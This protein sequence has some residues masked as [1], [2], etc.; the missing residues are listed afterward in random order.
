MHC[1]ETVIVLHIHVAPKSFKLPFKAAHR[2]FVA[3]GSTMAVGD[4]CVDIICAER[5]LL[6]ESHAAAF[7]QNSFGVLPPLAIH[8]SYKDAP[9]PGYTA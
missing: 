9:K 1:S 4:E 2:H 7:S 8:S 5:R 3:R 6:A